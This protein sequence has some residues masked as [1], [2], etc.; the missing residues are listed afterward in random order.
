MVSPDRRSVAGAR[1][2]VG[3]LLGCLLGMSSG[4]L[5]PRI[6]LSSCPSC[7]DSDHD[8]VGPT[9]V[10]PRQLETWM[11]TG[12][13]PRRPAAKASRNAPAKST[14]QCSPRGFG[15]SAQSA[16]ARARACGASLIVIPRGRSL[17]KSL[18]GRADVRL[19]STRSTFC[20]ATQSGTPADALTAA[21]SSLE[22]PA[23]GDVG[24][25]ALPTAAQPHAA[26]PIMALAAM[27]VSTVRVSAPSGRLGLS[28]SSVGLLC[29]I[30]ASSLS[31]HRR[32]RKS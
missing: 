28:A 30:I 7:G 25:P 17:R 29:P 32:R 16:N 23:F 22:W 20:A 15:G 26:T 14:E 9:P 13:K 3:T 18:A 12:W 2:G 27:P 24:C 1:Y 31:S 5:P 19:T 6:W 4:A 8:R 21:A 11:R 10:T